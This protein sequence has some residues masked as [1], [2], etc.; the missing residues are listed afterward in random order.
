MR[1]D[2]EFTLQNMPSETEDVDPSFCYETNTA[3]T[4]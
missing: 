1:P 3:F 4:M 2:T